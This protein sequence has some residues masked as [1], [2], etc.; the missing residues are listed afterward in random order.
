[1]S[2]DVQAPVARRRLWVLIASESLSS[3]GTQVTWLALPW[4]VLTT[5]GSPTRMGV[6]FAAELIPIALLGIP[7]GSLVARW[8]ARQTM[9]W[10]DAAR[11]VLIAAF[12]VLHFLGLLSFPVLLA[13][14]VLVGSCTAPY[15]GAQRIAV[16]DVVGADE[17]AMVRGNGLLES[18]TR[19]A[20]LL[21]PA[22]GGAL[23][24][25]LGS[26]TVLWI[27]AATYLVSFLMLQAL[28]RREADPEGQE[29]PGVLAGARAIL[30]DWVLSR[31]ALL[32]TL[33]GFAFPILIASLPVMALERYDGSPRAAGYLLAAWGGGALVGALLVSRLASQIKPWP[34]G[35]F[36]AVMFAAP[37]WGLT[38]SLPIVAVGCLLCVTGIATSA[39]NAPIISLFLARTDP[40]V[41]AHAITALMT[42]NLLAGPLGYLLAGPLLAAIGISGTCAVVAS[43]ASLAAL[44]MV[45]LTF[46]A[47]REEA[48]PSLDAA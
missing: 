48:K 8:G 9:L 16:V 7:S 37:L 28:P 5:S 34:L 31:L 43:I 35:R 15:L 42:A 10:C 38:G 41:Q 17:A 6:V 12:P 25:A 23:I 44:L 19:F 30:S 26:F 39:L 11:A 21:G 14:V 18:G 47:V 13:L 4:F 46:I 45:Q 1:M 33:Y 40:A 36:A 32:A 24:A 3:I 29:R 22:V 20:N 2:T 27:D